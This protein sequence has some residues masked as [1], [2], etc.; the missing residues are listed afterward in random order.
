MVEPTPQTWKNEMGLTS[1]KSNS[2]KL[3]E[4]LF[5]VRLK[6][7]VPKGKVDDVSEALLLAVYGFKK[8]DENTGEK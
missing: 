2:I 3:A 5:E 6:D 1:E 4:D 7:Y 8:Y